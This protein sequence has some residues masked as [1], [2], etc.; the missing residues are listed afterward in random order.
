MTG[1]TLIFLVM[2]KI[3]IVE[4]K[5]EEEEGGGEGQVIIVDKTAKLDNFVIVVRSKS[6]GGG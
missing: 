6:G 4:N 5:Y 2:V 3:N 1:T